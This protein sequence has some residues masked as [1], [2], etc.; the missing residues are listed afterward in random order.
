MTLT[1]RYRPGAV[2]TPFV[3]REDVLAI[4]DSCLASSETARVLALIGVGGIGKSR[5]LHEVL[6]RAGA[7][8]PT[9]ATALLNL[10][11]PSQRSQ[12]GALASL[13][14]QFGLNGV[15]FDRFD[16]AYAVWWQRLNPQL[17]LSVERFPLALL[18]EPIST[19]LNEATGVPVFGSALRVVEILSRRLRRWKTIRNDPTLQELDDLPHDRVGDAVTYLFAQ[20]LNEHGRYLLCVDAYEALVDDSTRLGQASWADV[21]LRDMVWQLDRGL[22]I[23]ASRR[24]VAWHRHH[25]QW[26]ERLY[27]VT[28]DGLPPE[29]RIE[30]LKDLGMDSPKLAEK[31]AEESAG[32]PYYLLL[33]SEAGPG[34]DAFPQ[35]EERFLRAVDP[36]VVRLLE[37]LSVARVFDFEIFSSLA[38]RF[39]F[40]PDALVW[41]RLV[42]YSFVSAAGTDT[43]QLHQLMARAIRARLSEQVQQELHEALC[44]TWRDRAGRTRSAQAWQE[45]A[46]H[47]ARVTAPSMGL[48]LECGDQTAHLDGRAGLQALLAD[49]PDLPRLRSLWLA[50]SALMIG[51]ASAAADA[52]ADASVDLAT[53][54]DELEARLAVAAA[55]AQRIAGNTIEALVRYGRV[56]STHPGPVALDAGAWHADLQMAQGRFADAISVAS[57]VAGRCP[58]ERHDL[59]GDLA[60]LKFLAYRFLFDTA[61]ARSHLDQARE[62]YR[63]AGHAVGLANVATNTVE[64]SALTDP[65]A[66]ITAATEAIGMQ[67]QFGAEH[68]LG[69]IYTAMSLAHLRLGNLSESRQALDR[70][71]EVLDRC[72]YRSGRARAE[73]ANAM[74]HA[75]SGSPGLAGRCAAWAVAELEAAAVYPTLIMLADSL[76]E[77]HNLADKQIAAAAARSAASVQAPAGTGDLRQLIEDHVDGVLLG[78]W[79][80]LYRNGQRQTAV[81]SGF[82]H[83]NVRVGDYL[84]R[85]PLESAAGMDLCIW[86]EPAVLAVVN[87]HLT[88]A[89]R[90]RATSDVPPYQVHDWINGTL[91][92]AAAPRGSAV[93]ASVPR[94]CAHLFAQLGE[95]PVERLPALPA[96]WPADGD[97]AAFAG[98]LLSH[99]KEIHHRYADRYRQLWADL[100]IPADPFEALDLNHLSSRPFRLLHSDVHRK[101][102]IL[103]PVE[104]ETVCRFLDWELALFGDPVYDLAVHLHKMGYRAAEEETMVRAWHEACRA[105]RWPGWS[106]DLRRYR[107]HE[108]VKSA[109]VDS[110]RYAQ[111]IAAVPTQRGAREASL[112]DKLDAARRVWGLSGRVDPARVSAALQAASGAMR[113]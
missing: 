94:Q 12:I 95:V 91:L 89:P 80:Q 32:L 38:A 100:E 37:L 19:V 59:L 17:P 113:R 1:P 85:T 46:Y 99:T 77:R 64:L 31:V 9:P 58:P 63:T 36:E 75:R 25:P 15:G 108:R 52:A 109:L 71:V 84:V 18:S 45:A 97:C 103:Q 101:N 82:Y 2:R 49:L 69:K 86:P 20:E 70:A 40:R 98:R 74:W 42:G 60:R 57:Q 56:W 24:P 104:D 90:L 78:H 50:E 55:H 93:P 16:I 83:R 62:H 87:A 21:W 81:L 47:G 34:P 68:E 61:T 5:L 72:G 43:L 92:D 112:V 10:Q 107:Q 4:F 88:S 11:E 105:D 13:R 30:L 33:A 67:E 54:S 8:A 14:S 111:I 96:Y 106:D 29:S 3:D 35:L 65:E 26:S 44:E 76:L 6:G 48:L 53:G 23:L 51:D 102:I 7:A 110:V 39:G 73:L 66:A 79:E 22:V 28:V 41:E 27:A